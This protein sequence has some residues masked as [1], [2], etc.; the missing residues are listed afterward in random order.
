MSSPGLFG[1]HMSNRDFNDSETWGKNQ[2]NSSFPA[3]LG[4]YLFSR[5]IPANYIESNSTGYYV[6][7]IDMSEVYGTDPLGTDAFFAFETSYTLYAPLVVGRLPGTDLVV[8]SASDARRQFRPLEIKLTALP[9]KATSL[10]SEDD[11]GSE[12]VIRPDTI[13]YL[14]CQLFLE[15]SSLVKD[16]FKKSKIDIKNNSDP[17]YAMSR[18][19]EMLTSLRGLSTADSLKSA[20]LL[21]QPVWKTVGQSSKLADDCLDVFIWSSR[22]FL[23]FICDIGFGTSNQTMT[24]QMRTVIWIYATLAEL[25]SYGKV[26]FAQIVDNLSFNTKN[27]KAFAANGRITNTYMKSPNLLKPRI[28]SSEIKN[29]ILGGGQNFLS[30]ERRFDAIIV[31]SPEIFAK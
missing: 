7:E 1:I 21:M 12:L 26:N 14:C 28:K 19:Q 22:A 5:G 31:N 13:L 30:P 9:D 2:F 15:N 18:L 10:L 20:P 27:D 6:D 17:D 4:C 3:A 8:C 25:A 24:R 29:I 11:Y 23:S 16:V